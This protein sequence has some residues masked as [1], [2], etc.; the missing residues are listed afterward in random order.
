VHVVATPGDG[1]IAVERSWSAT[2][3]RGTQT[4]AMR[5][6]L[7][8]PPERVIDAA[9]RLIALRTLLPVA[10]VGW[11][12]AWYGSAERALAKV[13]QALRIGGSRGG[14]S[15]AAG[16]LLRDLGRIRLRLDRVR[17]LTER[18]AERVDA[19][20][21]E[22]GPASRYESATYRIE[23]NNVKL[24][25]SE[26]C[27]AVAD[28]L[29]TIAGLKKGYLQDDPDGLERT[30]RDLRS[31]PLMFANEHLYQSNGRLMLFERAALHELTG[32]ADDSA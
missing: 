20:G 17:A 28:E 12:G 16:E 31:A 4:V 6:D 2:G 21:T 11:A 13:I 14:R 30:Y 25:A 8:V 15:L 9:P 23:L 22:D 7:T 1:E 29:I 24:L 19:W 32:P 10:H 26:D 18:L 27:C 5:F 3:M